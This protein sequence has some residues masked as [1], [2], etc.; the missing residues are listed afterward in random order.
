MTRHPIPIA[1]FMV[2]PH[3]LWST[4]HLLLTSGDFAEGRFNAMT[5]GW[6]SVGVMWGKP[7]VQVVVRP[8]R[9]TYEFMERY[10]TF[11]VCAFPREHSPALDLLGSKS[12]R[13]GNKVAESGLTPTAS[14]KVAAPSYREAEL[15]LECRKIYW[16]DME[17][18]H[19]LDPHIEENYSRL[20]YHRIYYGEIVAVF[21][22]E[23]YVA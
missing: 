5:V 17:R 18:S 13:D 20:D 8:T 19:F 21:G 11:T 6:G 23:Q 9:Y 7:F 22:E 12:G 16:D 14:T 3:H 2:K 4:Q 15:T 1:R 10:D